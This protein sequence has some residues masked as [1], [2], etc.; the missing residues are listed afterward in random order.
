MKRVVLGFSGGVDSAVSSV[1]LKK[2]GYDVIGVYLDNASA[3]EREYA[4]KAADLMKQGMRAFFFFFFERR[5][6]E[7]VHTLQ[8]LSEV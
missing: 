7:S 2:A 3:A 6:P 1:L 4:E 5:D 8:S